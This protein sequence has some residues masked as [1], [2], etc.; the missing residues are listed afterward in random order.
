M[1]IC[2]TLDRSEHDRIVSASGDLW[3]VGKQGLQSEH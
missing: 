2:T 1:A 3:R